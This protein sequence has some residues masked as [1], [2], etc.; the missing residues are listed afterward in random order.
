[1]PAS[2]DTPLQRILNAPNWRARFFEAAA[3]AS[4][5]LVEYSLR[6]QD[7]INASLW[8]DRLRFFREKAKLSRQPRTAFH[9]S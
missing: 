4:A 9:A 2:S 7:A 8:M 6:R 3:N 5:S 1:M